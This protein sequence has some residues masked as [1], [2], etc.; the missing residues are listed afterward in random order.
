MSHCFF[1]YG[2]IVSWC[3][4]KQR[5]ISISTT[6]AKYIAL[7]HAARKSVWIRRFLNELNVVDLIGACILHGDNK[8]SIILTKNAESQTRT[9]HIDV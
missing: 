9:K 7:G 5:T 3:N 4:K 1:L 6:E 2:A 8:T